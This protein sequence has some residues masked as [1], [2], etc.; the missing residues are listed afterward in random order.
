MHTIFIM[1]V[2]A[3]LST[4]STWCQPLNNRLPLLAANWSLRLLICNLY[5]FIKHS[6]S[7]YVLVSPGSCLPVLMAPALAIIQAQ[8]ITNTIKTLQ[9]KLFIV[10]WGSCVWQ[11]KTGFHRRELLMPHTPC[12]GFTLRFISVTENMPHARYESCESCHS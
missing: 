4:S 5:Y 3:C 9:E 11:L 12:K 10:V 8:N 1:H 2:Y 7:L 6:F